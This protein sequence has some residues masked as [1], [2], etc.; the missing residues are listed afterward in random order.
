MLLATGFKFSSSIT[1]NSALTH[2]PYRSTYCRG[3]ESE[4]DIFEIPITI[5]DEYGILGDR[6]DDAIDVANRIARHGGVVNLLIHTDILDHK[7]EFEKGFIAEFKQR[8]WFSTLGEFGRWWAVRDSATLTIAA[9]SPGSKRIGVNIKG[10]IDGLGLR[11]Q[12]QWTY[13]GGLHGTIQQGDILLLPE[14]SR[15][16]ELE[17]SV[18]P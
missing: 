7:L 5:E 13:L 3:Y 6:L 18:S 2:L 4:I 11:I 15:H 8:A 17:F 12:R 10:T 14:F 16:A 9:D 1:A